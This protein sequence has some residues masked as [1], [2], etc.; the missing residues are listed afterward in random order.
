VGC[1]LPENGWIENLLSLAPVQQEE[2]RELLEM[3]DRRDGWKTWGTVLKQLQGKYGLTRWYEQ[4]VSRYLNKLTQWQILLKKEEIVDR[5]KHTY[6]RPNP[7]KLGP[8]LAFHKIM[9]LERILKKGLKDGADDVYSYSEAPWPSFYGPMVGGSF[10]HFYPNP[11]WEYNIDFRIFGFPKDEELLPVERAVL[12]H[13]V[14]RIEEYFRWLGWLRAKVI[15]R[16]LYGIQMPLEDDLSTVLLELGKGDERKSSKRL[17]REARKSFGENLSLPEP[18]SIAERP[19]YWSLFLRLRKEGYA[20]N[21]ALTVTSGPGRVALTDE[22]LCL[23]TDDEKSPPLPP[24]TLPRQVDYGKLEGD[25]LV[26]IS[27]EARLPKVRAYN[28]L[29]FEVR[30]AILLHGSKYTVERVTGKATTEKLKSG[31]LPLT[32]FRVFD[33]HEI[34]EEIKKTKL[35]T[36]PS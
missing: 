11:F 33:W 35:L 31:Q 22:G 19:N 18:M 17:S 1:E 6:Y 12:R 8:M 3:W 30:P 5:V 36:T 24:L 13:I 21:L 2:L 34:E 20:N 10:F 23:N 16:R 7:G 9:Y 32:K 25:I 28:P 15:A 27:D 29:P 14:T 26:K 4:K